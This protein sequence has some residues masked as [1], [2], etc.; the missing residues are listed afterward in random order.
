MPLPL[1]VDAA[2]ATAIAI[3]ETTSG[4]LP[5]QMPLQPSL[6]R[7]AA[8]EQTRWAAAN[9]GV[10]RTKGQTPQNPTRARAASHAWNAEVRATSTGAGAVWERT[11]APEH[12]GHVGSLLLEAR[13]AHDARLDLGEGALRRGVLARCGDVARPPAPSHSPP[14]WGRTLSAGITRTPSQRGTSPA[15]PSLRRT[16]R[17]TC[18]CAPA[19]LV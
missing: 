19:R 18:Y 2:T 3:A 16:S 11:G 7:V 6:C 10:P 15:P 4:R 17:S 12:A 13:A 5:L 1:Q 8:R 14:P 9:R